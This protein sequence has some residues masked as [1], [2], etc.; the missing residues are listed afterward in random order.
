MGN[1]EVGMGAIEARTLLSHWPR[2]IYRRKT[3][4][5]KVYDK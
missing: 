3:R 2:F 5:C 1:D 4:P